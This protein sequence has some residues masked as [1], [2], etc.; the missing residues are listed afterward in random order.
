MGVLKAAES[1]DPILPRGALPGI[2]A[3]GVTSLEYFEEPPIIDTTPDGGLR[4]WLVVLG[5]FLTFFVT[6]G[7]FLE[8]AI[9]LIAGHFKL[10]RKHTDTLKGSS[11]R[12]EHFKHIIKRAF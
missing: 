10:W 12:S 5:G 9:L 4:A 2:L 1:A 11:T 8:Q 3:S 7:R 6:F